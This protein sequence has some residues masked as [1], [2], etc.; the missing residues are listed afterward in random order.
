MKKIIAILAVLCLT[1]GCL[2]GCGPAEEAAIAEDPNT[3]PEDTYEINWYLMC[4]AQNDVSSVETAINEYLKDKINATVKLNCL[5][6][7]QYQQKVSTMINANEYL[8]LCFVSAWALN[9]TENSRAGAFVALD[10]YL[11]TYLK[12]AAANFDEE[13]L[14]YAR[15]D[16]SL[17]ALPT[18]KELTTQLGWV[19]RKDIADKYNIDMTQYKT[20]EDLE[21]VLQM[22]KENEPDMNYPI[23]WSSGGTPDVLY[24]ANLNF[25]PVN[26]TL[27]E[28][29]A[30]NVYDTEEF[31]RSCEVARDYYNKGL[32]RP[33]VLTATDM[34]Q[35]MKEGKTFAIMTQIKPGKA[36]ELF[37]D[38]AYEFAQADI[39]VP[40]IDYLAGTGS[41]QAIPASSKNP[42][43]VMR[44]LNL[45]NTDPYLKNLVIH[46]IE[47]KHYNKIDENTIEM[48]PGSG[49]DL[50]DS[51]WAIG[52][53]FLDYVLTSEDPTKL[54][55]L[56]NY[57]QIAV[58]RKPN[59]FSPEQ[60]D[61]MERIK[62]EI[63]NVVDKYK[64]QLST[65]AVD[66]DGV[67][68]EFNEQLN[69]CGMQEYI[70][71]LQGQYDAY[72]QTLE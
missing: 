45:L 20:F 71:W 24:N 41:M 19:Y 51:S 26:G 9:Y 54:E 18:N 52:N 16:G 10:D 56:Q 37:G 57:N 4:E 42:A 48:I 17:Y 44:F 23:D 59:G 25:I 38:S 14:D 67:I 15:V 58:D 12:D 49:Y 11:D 34:L 72:L 5:P 60:D 53:I 28:E 7:G 43:R 13:I 65:G 66:P 62:T 8:D 40:Y 2:I 36:E 68:E 61:E 22:I 39:T 31:R 6:S 29:Q 30:V 46:G 64:K 35:R 3:V 47:G 21:P 1:A 69:Q 70:D 55:Q 50:H 63:D 33:D 27:S 32:V